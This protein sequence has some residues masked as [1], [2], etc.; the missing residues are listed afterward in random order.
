MDAISWAAGGKPPHD[1]VASPVYRFSR[2]SPPPGINI[3]GI[4]AK[5]FDSGQHVLINF[6]VHQESVHVDMVCKF[7]TDLSKRERQRFISSECSWYETQLRP[8][9]FTELDRF[10]DLFVSGDMAINDVHA[11]SFVTFISGLVDSWLLEV[12]TNDAFKAKGKNIFAWSFEC[13]V[14]YTYWAAFQPK[15]TLGIYF[16]K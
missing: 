8:T 16:E 4:V 12:S 6:G 2:D 7:S 3:G 13:K 1:K 10:K 11:A 15:Q 9:D 5:D 14:A